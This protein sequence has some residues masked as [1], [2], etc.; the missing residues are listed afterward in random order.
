MVPFHRLN[1]VLSCM[2]A[3]Q[4]SMI[5]MR[6]NLQERRGRLGSEHDCRINLKAELD[7]RHLHEKVDHLLTGQWEGLAEIQQIQIGLMAEAAASKR[8]QQ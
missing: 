8:P 6:Q 4:A 1:L 2:A 3:M 7:I 5:M